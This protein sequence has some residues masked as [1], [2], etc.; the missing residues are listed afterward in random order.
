MFLTLNILIFNPSQV[1]FEWCDVGMWLTPYHLWNATS[2]P[3]DL[4]PGLDH[5]QHF[6]L[7]MIVSSLSC[8]NY[9]RLVTYFFKIIWSILNALCFYLNFRISLSGSV[10][11]PC[12]DYFLELLWMCSRII[13]KKSTCLRAWIFPFTNKLPLSIDLALF[14][15]HSY[16][17]IFF[18]NDFGLCWLV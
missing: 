13:C 2:L 1:V 5:L 12:R 10:E 18:H 15:L 7:H 3:I 17:K 14:V 16:F 9:S 4:F 6:L 8:F 11:N